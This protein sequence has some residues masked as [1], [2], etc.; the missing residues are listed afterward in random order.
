MLF[1]SR[2]ADWVNTEI[3][4]RILIPLSE[5]VEIN[6]TQ[7]QPG[8]AL[9]HNVFEFDAGSISYL[10]YPC[11]VKLYIDQK[12]AGLQAMILEG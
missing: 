1:R 2:Q 7:I 10:K 4:V 11:D 3:N 12:V 6:L 5:P 8:T 9:G